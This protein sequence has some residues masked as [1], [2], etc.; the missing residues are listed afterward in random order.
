MAAMLQPTMT[1]MTTTMMMMKKKM[2]MMKIVEVLSLFV[3]I[4]TKERVSKMLLALTMMSTLMLRTK[5]IR[6]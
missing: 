4:G 2:M 1:M 6:K 5:K 3:V